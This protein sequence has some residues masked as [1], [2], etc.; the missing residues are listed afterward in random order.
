MV[1][2]EIDDFMAFVQKKATELF[3][4]AVSVDICINSQEVELVPRYCGELCSDRSMM[5]LDGNWCTKREET[6]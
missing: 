1:K 3:P 6:K 5:Q 2:K 4:N